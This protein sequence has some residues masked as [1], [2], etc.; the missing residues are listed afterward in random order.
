MGLDL[1]SWL[2][3]KPERKL[4]TPVSVTSVRFIGEQDGPVERDVK[5]RWFPILTAHPQIRRA[6]L[7]RASYDDQGGQQVVLALCSSGGPDFALIE[8]L[9]A[10]FA[11]MFSRACPLDMVFANAAQESQIEMVCPPFYTAA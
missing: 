6:F 10:P 2:K 4:V 3:K 8:A 9:R 11:A 7:V 5:S 1:L